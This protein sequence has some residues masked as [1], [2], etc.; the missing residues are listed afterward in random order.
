[1]HEQLQPDHIPAVVSLAASRDN[2]R[3]VTVAFHSCLD[4]YESST[5]FWETRA[6][7][8][9][10]IERLKSGKIIA[11]LPTVR[12]CASRLVLRLVR[13]KEAKSSGGNQTI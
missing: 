3:R 12:S 7:L 10:E 13:K 11:C 8:A 1:M 9:L 4:G 6:C 2:E 5:T